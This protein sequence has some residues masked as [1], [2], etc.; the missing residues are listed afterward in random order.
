MD[1][2]STVGVDLGKQVFELHGAAVDGRG[3][4]KL[5]CNEGSHDAGRFRRS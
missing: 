3:H 5:N 2:I 4:R 1:K